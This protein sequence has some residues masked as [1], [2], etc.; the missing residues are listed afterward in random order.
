MMEFDLH[1]DMSLTMDWGLDSSFQ[2]DGLLDD[3]KSSLL[4]DSPSLL[5][6]VSP[7]DGEDILSA[8]WMES[9]DIASFLD[10]LGDDPRHLLPVDDVPRH[11][12]SVDDV[13]AFEVDSNNVE[14]KTEPESVPPVIVLENVLTPSEYSIDS[15]SDFF[16][17]PPESPEPITPVPIPLPL[18]SETALPFDAWLDDHT[19]SFTSPEFN[20][21]SFGDNII[22]LSNPV[23]LCPT[24]NS[25]ASPESSQSSLSVPSSP[26]SCQ[27]SRIIDSSPEL[28]KAI[29]TSSINRFSPYQSSPKQKVKK[30]KATRKPHA[31]PVPEH[32]IMEELNKKDRKKMQNKNAAIR[33]R[34]KKREEAMGIKSEED[35]LEDINTTLKAK[36]DDLQREIRYMKNL[37]IDVLKAKG[38]R[39]QL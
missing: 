27:S 3:L 6:E 31:Q 4:V 1:T 16:L 12:L 22:S 28:Y 26:L 39:V 25:A 37:M 7:V 33:Y 23:E 36:V 13:P 18:E 21:I 9:A 17:S 38:I 30:S 35:Q 10:V 8:E 11:L 24:P 2:V 34:M 14:V 29:S 5:H 32:V 15:N 20:V 19:E